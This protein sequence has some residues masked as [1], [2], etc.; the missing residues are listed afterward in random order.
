MGK[1]FQ[2]VLA[3]LLMLAIPLQGLAAA[4]MSNCVP[5]HHG[6]AQVTLSKVEVA[7]WSSE[8]SILAVVGGV[9]GPRGGL[10][11]I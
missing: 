9:P 1:S 10:V 11:F 6:D 3:C 7:Y 4:A 2:R 5:G 8:E